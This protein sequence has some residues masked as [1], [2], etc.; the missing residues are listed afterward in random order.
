MEKCASELKET[1][2]RRVFIA[3]TDSTPT[4][5]SLEGS[6]ENVNEKGLVFGV[7]LVES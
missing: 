3:V 4:V 5:N 6:V 7:N 1:V 2:P